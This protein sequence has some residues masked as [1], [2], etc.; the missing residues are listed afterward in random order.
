[1]ATFDIFI[2]WLLGP[3]VEGGYVNNP[4]DPGGETRFGIAKRYH[5]DVDIKNLTRDGAISIY[6][7]Q[8]WDAIHGD[9]L[10]PAIAFML[11]DADI[12]EGGGTAVV[13]L[14]HALGVAVDGRLGPVTLAAEHLATPRTLLLEIAARR[15]VAYAEDPNEASFELGWARR[16][17]SCVAASSALL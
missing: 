6:R 9:D 1:M 8:Y 4:S 13:I 17:M 12:N 5:Q 15:M 10:H 14:Q 2:D 3:N 7:I 11:C 16:L